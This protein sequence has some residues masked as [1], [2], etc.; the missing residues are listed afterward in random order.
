MY[1]KSLTSMKLIFYVAILVF[2]FGCCSRD[3]L[4]GFLLG[5]YVNQPQEGEEGWHGK[6]FSYS[7]NDSFKKMQGI[8]KEIGVKVRYK[9]KDKHT[10]LAW[11][12]DKVY[13]SC[14]DTT[15]VTISFEEIDSKTTRISV[16]CGNYGLAEF[17]A[18]E[19]FS[20]LEK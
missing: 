1:K 12:F 6:T 20:H 13:D 7:Y 16:A 19:I 14:I 18:K 10:I 2:I 5:T 15:K 9:S 8:L 17:A 11:Y 3:N 4:P